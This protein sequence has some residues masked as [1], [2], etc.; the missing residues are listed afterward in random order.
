MKNRQNCHIRQN[1]LLIVGGG[2]RL[3]GCG[4]ISLTSNSK[5]NGLNETIPSQY[6]AHFC[7]EQVDTTEGCLKN[8][9]FTF[10]GHDRVLHIG[11][12]YGV[13]PKGLCLYSF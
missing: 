9:L 4:Q 13:G 7:A 8:D 10:N 2:K 11:W 5:A 3:V 12:S 1:F 6:G